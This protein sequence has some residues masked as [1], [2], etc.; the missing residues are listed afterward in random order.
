[1]KQPL[2][3]RYLPAGAAFAGILT[4]VN[5][6]AVLPILAF[7]DIAAMQKKPEELLSIIE[8]VIGGN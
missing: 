1:M 7:Q 4:A 5:S 6:K 2:R 3:R 8:H